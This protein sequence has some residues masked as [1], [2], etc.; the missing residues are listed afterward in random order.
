MVGESPT[1]EFKDAP[2]A[3][4]ARTGDS[5]SGDKPDVPEA[6]KNLVN[7]WLEKIKKAAK[8]HK[9]AFDRMDKCMKIAVDGT[10]EKTW[11]DGD[12]YVVPIVN[13]HI[14][15]C[16][17]QLYAKDPRLLASRRKKLMFQLWDGDPNTYQAALVA[18]QQPTMI[19]PAGNQQ[20]PDPMW[21]PDPNAAALVQE[22]QQAQEYIARVDK[23]GKSVE[24]LW[25]YFTAEQANGFKQQMKAL[26]RRT[27]VC[28]AGYVEL[29]FQRDLERSPEIDAQIDDATDQVKKIAAGMEAAEA[30]KIEEDSARA[31][32]LR[33][34]IEQLQR[35]V[36]VIA[37]E[38][39]LFDFPRSKDIIVDLDCKHLKTFTGARWVARKFDK[40][41]EKVKTDYGVDITGCFTAHKPADGDKNS[42]KAKSL[43]RLYRVQD[44]ENGQV[45]VVCEGYHDFIVA[46]KEPDVKIERFWTTFPLVFNEVESEDDLYP[47]SDVW[48]LRHPQAEMNRSRESLREHRMAN[49]PKYAAAKGALE[50]T[51]KD[52]LATA[53]AH[54]ILELKSIKPGQDVNQLLMAIKGAPIDPNL[55]DVSPFYMDVLRGVGTQEANL[56]GTSDS[57]ATESSI[58]EQSRN[59]SLADNVDDL[60]DLLTELGRGFGQLC[61]ME[62][63]QDTVAEIVGPGATWPGLQGGREQIVKDL[64]L[65]IQGGSSGRPNKA[66]ELA[67]MERGIPY[68]L[69]MPGVNPKVLVRK[70]TALLDMDADEISAEG[71]PSITALNALASKAAAGGGDPNDPKAQGPQGSQNTKGPQQN[72]N[73]PGGQ[74][75]YPVMDFDQMGNRVGAAA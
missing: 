70:Y 74:P 38:G 26:V 63:S 24:L 46:P 34:L 51:D 64:M 2:R 53:P 67:N 8:H 49:R 48:L 69:Q 27:K 54:S 55:Y 16:V 10:A 5:Y 62:L 50:K 58:A 15:Q 6:R 36:E 30:G 73:E 41:P 33:L 68:L 7:E 44:K 1:T 28:G 59:A 57:T 39:P 23:I 9:P 25:R 19:D 32:E 61:L 52:L 60:D 75:A 37:R 21:Q 31:E 13:R 71:L 20:A 43:A 29:A 47:P 56:G 14:N 22:V 4:E 17:S 45:F 12:S 18:T 3:A 72:E 42:E 35:Q 66:A 11:V 40:T 65:D